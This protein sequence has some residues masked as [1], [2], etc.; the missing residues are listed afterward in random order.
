MLPLR[1]NEHNLRRLLPDA[2]IRKYV[3]EELIRAA[4]THI[5]EL[6]SPKGHA[7]RILCN[8]AHKYMVTFTP[9]VA[10]YDGNT[11]LM[12]YIL[13]GGTKQ[14]HTFRDVA[15]R[16]DIPLALLLTPE[17]MQD[18]TIY[19][20]RF[21]I[22]RGDTALDAA[23]KAPLQHGYFGITK[24][25]AFTRYREHQAKA[26]NAEGHLLHTVWAGLM[27]SSVEYHPVLQI[28]GYADT[29][30]KAYAYEEFVVA[31]MSLAPMG[32]NAIPGGEAGIKML[33]SLALLKGGRKLAGVGER[34]AA[35]ERLERRAGKSG[36]P[37]AHYRKG[38]FRN[39]QSGKIAWV[40]P[41]WVNLKKAEHV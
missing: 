20:I 24:R 13:K 19:H 7:I 5:A 18:Y 23:S 28:S 36:S 26:L 38:H 14:I 21:C 29:L 22:D 6:V 11:R 10:P 12:L 31:Q 1:I 35:I 39:I 16:I 33:H 37:C 34:D 4:R 8:P 15:I 41:C 17:K 40:S 30:K 27:R 25:D 2:A 32:L 3:S 9:V